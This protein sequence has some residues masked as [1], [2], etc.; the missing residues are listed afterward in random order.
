MDKTLLN[1]LM[2][3][4]GSFAGGM[5]AVGS[6]NV[7]VPNNRSWKNELPK[8]KKRRLRKKIAKKTKQKNR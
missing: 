4:S 5:G 3:A 2:L 6:S 1:Y 8:V 7:D